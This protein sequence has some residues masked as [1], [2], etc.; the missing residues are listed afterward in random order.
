VPNLGTSPNSGPLVGKVLA[1]DG[2]FREHLPVIKDERRHVALRVDLPVVA[3]VGRSFVRDVDFF[4]VDYVSR[5][6]GD[7]VWGH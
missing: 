1:D 5:F 6:E 2:D 3:A 7:D 4:Q